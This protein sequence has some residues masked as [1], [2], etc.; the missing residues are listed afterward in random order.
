MRLVLALFAAVVLVGCIAVDTTREV[1]TSAPPPPTPP[2]LNS[3]E[4]AGTVTV[5]ETS[6]AG[7]ATIVTVGYENSTAITLV[8][9][10]VR[11]R[12]FDKDGFQ[13]AVQD[14]EIVGW[15]EG[16]IVPGFKI[17][18]QLDL[19]SSAIASVT[20]GVYRAGAP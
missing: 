19:V 20:C 12:G 8:R 10:T 9:V 17:R 1:H 4:A 3:P 6:P 16:P 15:R 7:N 13:V 14:A 5:F 11:C 2:I 18:T